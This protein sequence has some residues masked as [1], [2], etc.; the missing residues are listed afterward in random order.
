MLSS[1]SGSVYALWFVRSPATARQQAR[2][3]RRPQASNCRIS[4]P[5]W[6]RVLVVSWKGLGRI[7]ASTAP[8]IFWRVATAKA[9]STAGFAKDRSAGSPAWWKSAKNAQPR[10]FAN[11]QWK[12]LHDFE[13]GRGY[14]GLLRISGFFGILAPRAVAF[15]LWDTVYKKFSNDTVCWE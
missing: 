2:S 5:A 12:K 15:P 1:S 3:A 7:S 10:Y 11:G 8:T 9:P 14:P 6:M 13:K 4:L